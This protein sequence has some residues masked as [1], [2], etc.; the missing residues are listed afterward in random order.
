MASMGGLS[1]PS[2][3]KNRFTKFVVL[4]QIF[5]L[6]TDEDATNGNA[7][8][9]TGPTRPHSHCRTNPATTS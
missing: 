9:Q 1:L 3:I 5:R 6:F 7:S 2:T 8:G 4:E